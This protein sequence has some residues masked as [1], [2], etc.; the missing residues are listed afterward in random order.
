[1]IFIFSYNKNIVVV[2]IIHQFLPHLTIIHFFLNYKNYF[3]LL[4]IIII[5][6]EM[7]AHVFFIQKEEQTEIV[8]MDISC[9]IYQSLDDAIESLNATFF[10]YFFI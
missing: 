10:K 3:L 4:F 1:M 2:Y 6:S 5:E 7:F 9:E 8:G